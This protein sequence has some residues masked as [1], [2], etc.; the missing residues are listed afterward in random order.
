MSP[1]ARTTVRHGG[2]GKCA[3]C[4]S[5][6]QRSIDD[7]LTLGVPYR[8]LALRYGIAK[9]SLIRHKQSHLKP[10]LTAVHREHVKAG[11]KTIV[12]RIEDLIS[13][14]DAVLDL[15]QRSGHASLFLQGVRE[16]REQL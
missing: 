10:S 2:R 4:D 8:V 12:A 3:A 14:T 5:P 15:A 6:D 1:T 13:R 7:D 11:A 9:S 16:M